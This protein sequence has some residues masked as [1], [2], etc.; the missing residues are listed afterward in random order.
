MRTL[1][2]HSRLAPNH[3]ASDRLVNTMLEQGPKPSL[4]KRCGDNAGSIVMIGLAVGGSYVG[5][6]RFHTCAGGWTSCA[7]TALIQGMAAT[8]LAP[9]PADP[10]PPVGNVQAPLTLTN[11]YVESRHNARSAPG[12][13]R[14]RPRPAAP[15]VAASL[16]ATGPRTPATAPSAVAPPRTAEPGRTDS[17][18]GG[19][20]HSDKPAVAT[21]VY[22]AA[23]TTLLVRPV[24]EVCDAGLKK[25]AVV[26]AR[27]I[28]SV[29]PTTGPELPA[30]TPV[31]LVVVDRRVAAGD[32]Y[33][34]I[35]L[36]GQAITTASASIPIESRDV[37]FVLQKPDVVGG[38]IR[39]SVIGA[40]AGAAVGIVLRKNVGQTA[41][42]G[43][44]A[45]GAIGA[46]R[47][48][49]GQACVDAAS[50]TFP[51]TLATA[52]KVP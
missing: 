19:V 39:G 51:I 42:V 9:K 30:G 18:F 27:T 4:L 44:A 29:S 28:T 12:A 46:A 16:P 26:E 21:T 32:Q 47:A 41:L 52:A 36:E 40:V 24:E 6:L 8:D 38:V 20:S 5:Y 37:R 11:N 31:R 10:R 49:N 1:G 3:L 15:I 48:A 45:G 23:K 33:P 34:V 17:A 7:N 14:S 25:G 43:A 35:A 13:S 50:T 22:L 2:E